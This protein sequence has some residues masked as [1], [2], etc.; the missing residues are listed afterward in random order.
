MDP[1]T[2][3]MPETVPPPPPAVVADPLP[4]VGAVENGLLELSNEP[5]S[6]GTVAPT[7]N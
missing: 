1:M 6:S 7:G 4:A 2:N 3:G 5:A